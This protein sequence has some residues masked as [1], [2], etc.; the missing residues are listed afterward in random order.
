MRRVIGM[1]SALSLLGAMAGCNHT[2]GI[3]D[4]DVRTWGCNGCCGGTCASP[5]QYG[6]CPPAP[7]APPVLMAPPGNGAI[8]KDG[9]KEVLPVPKETPKEAPK[10]VNPDEP[11]L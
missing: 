8:I 3:C 5:S 2:A 1:L 9:P 10:K 11:Q 4:C 7:M 6:C